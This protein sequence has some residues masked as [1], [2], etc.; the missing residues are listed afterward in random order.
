MT[1][2][3]VS[4]Q[5][6]EIKRLPTRLQHRLEARNSKSLRF[7]Q[8]EHACDLSLRVDAIGPLRGRKRCCLPCLM[9]VGCV[10]RF[11]IVT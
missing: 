3:A 10:V 2:G 1:I 9:S 4:T 7:V 5:R 11:M 6:S 8:L